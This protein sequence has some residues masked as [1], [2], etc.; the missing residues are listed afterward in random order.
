MTIKKRYIIILIILLAVFAIAYVYQT[1]SNKIIV[2]TGKEKIKINDIITGRTVENNTI[3]LKNNQDYAISLYKPG[4]L[5]GIIIYNKD[6]EK[7]RLT[8]EDYFLNILD[9]SKNDACKLKIGLYVSRYT[10]EEIG[11]GV[12]YGL[13]FCPNGKPFPTY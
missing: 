1:Y 10:N 13:S 3:I 9:I 2:D 8:A 4:L 6:I 5:F 11:G 7:T 12:N